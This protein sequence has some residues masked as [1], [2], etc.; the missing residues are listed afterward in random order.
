MKNLKE[1]GNNQLGLYYK[2]IEQDL[3]C[4]QKEILQQ[5]L[6]I[7]KKIP[8]IDYITYNE[9][10]KFKEVCLPYRQKIEEKNKKKFIETIQEQEELKQE[11][12]IRQKNMLKKIKA[13]PP[14][15]QT[16]TIT[17]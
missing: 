1:L 15:L 12:K 4:I 8:H 2:K 17:E 10:K 16:Q 6:D 11:I 5:I 13:R 7:F 14:S 9:P 3:N